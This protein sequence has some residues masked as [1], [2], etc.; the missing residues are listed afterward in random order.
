M[1]AAMGRVNEGVIIYARDGSQ[2]MNFP[3]QHHENGKAKRERTARRFKRVVRT[4]KRLRDELVSLGKLRPGQVPSF[5][6]ESL[7]YGV[8]D[9]VFLH[10]EDD[11]YGRMSRVLLRLAEQA[12]DQSWQAAAREI[13]D[14]KPLFLAGQSWSVADARAFIAFAIMRFRA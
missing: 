4:A 13:N 8:E 9:Q 7:V 2:T 11:R 5:L 6:V 3:H 14:V 10:A 12:S 1:L